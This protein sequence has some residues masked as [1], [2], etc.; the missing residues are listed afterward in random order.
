MKSVRYILI[1]LA[2]AALASTTASAQGTLADYQR[3]EQYLP[4]NISK[5]VRNLD[6]NPNWTTNG[7]WYIEQLPNGH[8]YVF[9]SSRNGTKRPAFDHQWLASV[10]TSRYRTNYRP[11]SLPLQKPVFSGDT[12]RFSLDSLEWIVE[13]RRKIAKVDKEE[14]PS[15]LKNQS[16]SPDGKWIVS[17]ENFNLWLTNTSTD[18]KTELTSD[19]IERHDYGT[20][21]S[22]YKTVELE[23][24]DIYDPEIMIKW[25]PDSKK[26]VTFRL[27]RRNM[28]RLYL[29]QSV[30]DSGM[31]AKVWHYDRPL[32]G[33]NTTKTFEFFIF[34]VEKKNQT[35]IAVEPF[36]DFL[37][38]VY[39]EWFNDSQRIFFSHF[40]R[41][42]QSLQAYTADASTG[43][44]DQLVYEQSPTMIEYQMA[45]SRLT[46]N[47]RYVIWASERDGWNHLYLYDV[48]KRELVRQLTRGEYVVR[49]I[50]YADD[51]HIW[52]VA[53]AK[54][55]GRDP[56]YRHLYRT[57]YNGAEPLLLTPEDADH[58]IRFSKDGKTFIDNISRIDMAPV[59][60]LRDSRT[61]RQI[62]EI[63][64][65]DV[66][67][68]ASIGYRMPVP[69]KV[70]C[71]YGKTDIW[72][73]IWYPSNFDPT[74]K[75]PVIDATYSGPQ[76]VRTP[77]SFIRGVS[78]QEHPLAELGFIVITVDGLGSALRS[79]EFHDYSYRNL[80]D[81]GSEDHIAAIL[82]LARQ[83]SY[84]DTTRVGIYG[85]SAGGYDAA[86]A[87]LIRP[88]F[89][90]VGVSSAGNHDFHMSKA[91]WDEQYMGL[92]DSHYTEQ[93]NLTAA[94]NL[95]GKLLLFTGDMDQNVNPANTLR[96]AAELVRHNKDFDLFLVPNADH[97]LSSHPYVIRRRWDYFVRH[98]L[99]VEPPVNY[100][101]RK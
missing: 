58:D 20:P 59:S 38:N 55:P 43:Q 77:K 70:K 91:W 40:T 75:Y 2:A 17:V 95:Q 18:E 28:R 29:Y 1:V 82:Q 62:A 98:L 94:P 84:I 80:G 85:H 14:K 25:S 39:P 83:H 66:S 67:Q 76:A 68:L 37:I 88:D 65:A 13:I 45:F 42:Y 19:G 6:V 99:D 69:F 57:D 74:R 22:W 9:V 90:K 21:V 89:Y 7:F 35:P 101:I 10:I 87:L 56:Y 23:K 97:D 48:Q 30:P 72:G 34:D 78:N 8:Q 71:R 15:L 32:P 31:R 47:N 3:A 100:M 12:L 16:K 96:L 5:R 27:D 26:F 54:E 51:K 86:R 52:F 4:F 64:R 60:Y 63:Q 92:P 61:G 11:D 36:S 44:V 24:G 79:K 93:S 50:V 81:I 73:A 49:S 41:G 53:G 46:D 33:E